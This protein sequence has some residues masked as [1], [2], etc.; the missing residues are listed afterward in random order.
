VL[1]SP[2]ALLDAVVPKDPS[3]RRIAAGLTFGPHARHR[4]DLYA[5]RTPEGPLPVL[6]FIYGGGWDSGRRE[7]YSFA[8]R[9]FAA[10][11]FLTAIA[12]YRVW[13]EVR[14]PVFVEDAA[15]AANWLIAHAAE[16]GGD[17]GRFVV[18]GHSAGAYNAVTLALAPARFGAPDL[19]S[20]INGAIGLSGPYDFFPFDVKQSIRAFG[21]IAEPEQSQPINLV[22]PQSPPMLLA[23]GGRDQTVAPYHSVRL[24]KKLREAGVPVTELPLPTL[25]HPGTVL[26]LMRP[27]RRQTALY[28][29]IVAFLAS[30]RHAAR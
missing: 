2:L 15:R 10:L 27:F 7:E 13:P 8:G 9:A 6:L 4:L 5:P 18:A 22:T 23:Q 11:G 16:H 12:D 21:G 19:A 29:E 30:I 1:P 20:R 17:P 24:S 25:G 3:S 14:Y 26:N 28:R